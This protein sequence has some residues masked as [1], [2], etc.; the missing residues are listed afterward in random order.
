MAS[1]T[2]KAETDYDSLI[3][4][5]EAAVEGLRD[6]YREQLTQ[7]VA[8]LGDL[9][10]RIETGGISNALLDE[11]HGIAHNVKGQGGSFGYDLVTEIGASFCDYLRSGRR[12]SPG[13]LNIINM[14][15]RMLRTV[16]ENDITGDGGETGLRIVEKLRLLTSGVKPAD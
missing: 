16:S 13:E 14:H 9:W 12:A 4:K 3:A 2:D 6:I 10:A 15:I 7:D 11:I 1:P 8:A 5:A